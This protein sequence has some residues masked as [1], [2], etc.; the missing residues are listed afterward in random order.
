MGKIDDSL[1]SD[2]VC[3]VYRI[4]EGYKCFYHGECVVEDTHVFTFQSDDLSDLREAFI[5]SQVAFW[6]EHEV[7]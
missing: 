3:R 6:D 1:T 4:Q 5:E 7:K 2:V